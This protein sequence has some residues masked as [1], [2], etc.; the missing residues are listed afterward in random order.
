VLLAAGA[1]SRFGDANKLLADVGGVAL[2]ARVAASLRALEL[3][4][5]I[6]V[7][8]PGPVGEGVAATLRDDRVRLAVNAA[9]AEGIGTSIRCG[10]HA[11]A[12]PDTGVMIVPGD[13]PNLDARLLERLLDEFRAMGG[14][15]IVYPVTRDGKQRN[16]V[17]WP[18][19]LRPA[20]QG[21]SPDA[22][23]KSLLTAHD[24]ETTRVPWSDERVFADIDT[25]NELLQARQDLQHYEPHRDRR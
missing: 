6:A 12:D 4:E 21:L 5:I 9:A 3:R 20:L 10:V 15:K 1:S 2:V 17:V 7:I 24:G 16:P 18:A 13:M 22:G 8:A 25:Q 14:D 19:R 11:L 23:G